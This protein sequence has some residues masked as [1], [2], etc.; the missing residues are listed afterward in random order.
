MSTSPP[1]IRSAGKSSRF[2]FVGEENG[3]SESTLCDARPFCS[4]D[5]ELQQFYKVH[6]HRKC[7][8]PEDDKAMKSSYVLLGKKMRFLN[9]GVGHRFLR[10]LEV[11]SK[12]P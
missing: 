5:E 6:E 4:T 1:S 2:S 12:R 9:K 7:V 11:E 8:V 10:P 3:G